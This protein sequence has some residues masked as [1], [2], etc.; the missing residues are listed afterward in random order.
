[1][2]MHKSV[3]GKMQKFNDLSQNEY[4]KQILKKMF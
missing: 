1:M 2:H 3:R 4:P